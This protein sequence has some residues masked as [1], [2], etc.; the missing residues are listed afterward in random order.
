MVEMND[1]IRLIGEMSGDT[2]KN[3][4][5]PEISVVKI[6]NDIVM[7]SKEMAKMFGFSIQQLVKN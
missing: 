3:S 2:Y 1:E 5:R 6:A 7:T 4:S